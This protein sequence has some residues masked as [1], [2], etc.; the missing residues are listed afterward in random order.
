M[1]KSSYIKFA[2]GIISGLMFLP[3]FTNAAGLCANYTGILPQ[4]PS[5]KDILN[6]GTCML[7]QSVVQILFGIALI[8]F[9]WGVI[10]FIANAENEEARKKGR[11]FIIWGIIGLFVMVAIWGLVKLLTT[12]TGIDFAAPALKQQ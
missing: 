8:I 11:D 3:L 7:G 2:S 10:Q 9:I 4:N 5:I 6:F 1:K 12:T